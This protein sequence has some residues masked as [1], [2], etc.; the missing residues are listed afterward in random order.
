[1][2]FTDPAF[3]GVLT[4]DGSKLRR[5]PGP[6]TASGVVGPAAFG[7]YADKLGY[8]GEVS[9]GSLVDRDPHDRYGRSKRLTGSMG[10][11]AFRAS[12]TFVQPTLAALRATKR[13][14]WVGKRSG[15]WAMA[16]TIAPLEVH[17]L[18][19]FSSSWRNSFDSGTQ[20]FLFDGKTMYMFNCQASS[21]TWPAIAPAYEAAVRS[22]RVAQ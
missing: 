14:F 21:K 5:G 17:G 22:F 7:F 8:R 4:F 19:G 13:L 9:G 12:R 10:I 6:T 3:G 1:M 20:Y 2:T 15:V 16:G 18:H 11:T